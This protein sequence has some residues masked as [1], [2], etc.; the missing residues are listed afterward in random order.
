MEAMR[1]E[2]R[3]LRSKRETSGLY[4]KNDYLERLISITPTQKYLDLQNKSTGH[5]LV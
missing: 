4:S 3:S 2:F 5:H 1:H